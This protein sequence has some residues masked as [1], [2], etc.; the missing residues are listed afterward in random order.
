MREQYHREYDVL[1]TLPPHPNIVR[2]LAFFYDRLGDSLP[3]MEQFD[4][5]RNHAR[6]MSL[7]L[8]MEYHPTTLAEAARRLREARQLTVSGFMFQV[9]NKTVFKYS[10]GTLSN[11]LS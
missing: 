11:N 6:S 9:F 7:M 10:L 3:D 1:A 2:L 4:A 8:V 5:L